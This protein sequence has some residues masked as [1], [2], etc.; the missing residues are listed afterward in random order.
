MRRKVVKIERGKS[1][2]SNGLGLKFGTYHYF[3]LSCGHVLTLE[4]NAA[5]WIK[6]VLTSPKTMNCDQCPASGRP[7]PAREE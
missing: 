5:R 7:A 6:G 4:H 2:R 1:T 3:H